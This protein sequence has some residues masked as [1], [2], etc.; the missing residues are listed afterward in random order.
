MV[1]LIMGSDRWWTWR[2]G[3]GVCWFDGL[4]GETLGRH[5]G[6]EAF[7]ETLL[8]ARRRYNDLRDA[9]AVGGW[10]FAIAQRKIVDA[11]RSR[12]R[13]PIVTDQLEEQIG[14]WHDPDPA[15]DVW[16]QV[17]ALP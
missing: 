8:A 4:G 15:N 1:Q 7:Q 5:R 14:A 17:A 3:G 11:A 6:E 12:A 16:S 9:R 2:R 10:L 13:A